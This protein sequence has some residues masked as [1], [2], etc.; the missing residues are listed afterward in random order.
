MGKTVAEG[1]HYDCSEDN[2]ESSPTVRAPWLHKVTKS[3]SRS[4]TTRDFAPAWL[5]EAQYRKG[6]EELT[7]QFSASTSDTRGT[8]VHHTPRA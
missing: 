4:A 1:F 2:P 7:R 8:P 3:M 6:I 5:D